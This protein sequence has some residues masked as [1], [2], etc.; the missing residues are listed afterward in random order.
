MYSSDLYA[1][2]GF[3]FPLLIVLVFVAWLLAI[4]LFVKAAK[5][6]GYYQDDSAQVLLLWFIGIFASP[7]V[8]G[9]YVSSLPDKRV[10]QSIAQSASD[11]SPASLNDE[12][13]SL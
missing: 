5:D 7:I 12:L 4:Y 8:V 2:V 1:L 10:Q 9:L 11:T 3:L 6:K 13:P